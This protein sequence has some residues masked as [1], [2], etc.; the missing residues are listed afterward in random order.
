MLVVDGMV[1]DRFG[2]I[3]RMQCRNFAGSIPPT[4]LVTLQLRAISGYAQRISAISG[5]AVIPD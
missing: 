5:S 3:L 1:I 2:K 4:M